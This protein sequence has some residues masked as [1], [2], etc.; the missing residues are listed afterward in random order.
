VALLLLVFAF[1]RRIGGPPAGVLAAGSLCLLK[2]G[3]S[4]GGSG[5]PLVDLSRFI[6]YDILVP[7]WVVAA[8]IAVLSAERLE[9]SYLRAGLCVGMATLAHVYGAFFLLPVVLCLAAWHGT[10]AFSL[11]RLPALLAGFALPLVP[12]AVYVLRDVPDYVGQ[13]TRHSERFTASASFLWSNLSREPERWSWWW[14]GPDGHVVLAPRPGFLILLA[15]LVLF[16]VAVRRRSALPLAE[17][18]GRDLVLASLLVLPLCLGLLLSFKRHPYVLLVLPFLAVAVGLVLVDLWRFTRGRALPRAALAVVLTAAAV[19]GASGLAA[20]LDEARHAPSYG[21]VCDAIARLV[22]PGERLLCLHHYWLGLSTYDFRSLDLPKVLSEKRYPHP[23]Q[24]TFEEAVDF[25][26]PG[27][28]VL[29]EGMM[30][31]GRTPAYHALN[32]SAARFWDDLSAYLR[33]RCTRVG[34]VSDP[35]YGTIGVYARRRSGE[36][37]EVTV[38]SRQPPGP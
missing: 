9:K 10:R 13:M 26:D 4:G 5:V 30:E 23:V 12:W 27:Y 1:A 6:R 35:G 16:A 20:G 37:P 21:R 11:R 2:L 8:G 36:T 29:E 3:A 7:V 32:P 38:T 15:C 18:R 22:P 25:V 33:T 19:E 31:D 14:R 24:R 28:V 34:A 17:A